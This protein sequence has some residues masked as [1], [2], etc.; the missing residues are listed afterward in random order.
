MVDRIRPKSVRSPGSPCAWSQEQV[1]SISDLIEYSDVSGGVGLVS[2]GTI[3]AGAA[4]IR[5]QVHVITAFNAGSGDALTVG[6]SSDY[7]YLVTDGHPDV[8]DSETEGEILDYTPSSA[9]TIYA[10]YTHSS[11]AP[12]AG[13]ARV[14]VLFKQPL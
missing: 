12:T 2:I 4:L 11:T 6:P 14:T 7:D 10:R 5:T 9:T 8:A 13:K 1:G 3:P